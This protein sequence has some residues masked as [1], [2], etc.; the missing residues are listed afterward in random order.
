VLPELAGDLHA[1]VRGVLVDD[2]RFV[3]DAATNRVRAAFDGV[4]AKASPV[5]AY[6]PDGAS[7]AVL[8]NPGAATTAVWAEAY[9][10]WS[11]MDSNGNAVERNR[12]IGGVV[13][14]L[15]GIVADTWRLGVLAG[16][17]NSSLDGSSSSAD[18]D[19]YQVG[20][21]GGTKWDALGLRFGASL[22][23]H[24]IDTHRSV[25]FA[26]ITDSNNASYDATSVQIFGEVGFEIKASLATFEPFA[27]IAYTYLKADDF[28]EEGG[29]TALS[30]LSGSNDVTT[31]TLGLRASRQFS[32]SDTTTLTANGMIGWHHAFGDT[33]PEAILA[34]AAGSAFSVEGLPIAKDAL[35]LQAGFDV[36][37]GKSTTLGLSYHGQ[38]ADNI[39]DHSIK[40]DISVKF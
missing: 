8:A 24:E 16:Y 28:S 37:L 2:N 4:S 27:G 20:L 13:T 33:T 22:A 12:S 32:L 18:V 7:E 9:G 6:G 3:R 23:H 30:G 26:G 35:A 17:A 10:S 5:L 25:D 21:Y 40:A 31:T 39:N 34:Y 15:D 19:S 1:S 29:V 38:I 36:N 14:G 11:H